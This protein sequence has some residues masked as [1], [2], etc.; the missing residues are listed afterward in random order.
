MASNGRIT[1]DLAIIGGGGGGLAAALAAAEGGCKNILVLEKA[2]APGGTTVMA[3]DIFGAE[4]P[5]QIREGIDAS[6]DFCFNRAMDWAHAWRRKTPTL[7]GLTSGMSPDRDSGSVATDSSCSSVRPW[8]RT[9]S[10]RCPSRSTL[11]TKNPSFSKSLRPYSKA[12]P[13]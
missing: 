5:V 10:T 2:A 7:V 9:D 12:G 3:H 1:T 11:T 4:S 8:V 6:R 13:M